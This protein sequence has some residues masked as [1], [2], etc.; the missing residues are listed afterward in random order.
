MEDLINNYLFSCKTPCA[1]QANRNS[2]PKIGA[3]VSICAASST[4]PL[5]DPVS[6]SRRHLNG[7][8]DF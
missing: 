7:G 1:I 6:L 3:I 2:T 8:N 5:H 4:E